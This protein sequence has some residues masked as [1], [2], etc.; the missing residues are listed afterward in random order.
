[1]TACG[2]ALVSAALVVPACRLGPDAPQ[3]IECLR[4]DFTTSPNRAPLSGGKTGTRA[5]RL[6]PRYSSRSG[7]T[8][9]VGYAACSL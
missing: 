1:M 8:E 6:C 7:Q 9:R 4:A 3:P 2:G 5:E